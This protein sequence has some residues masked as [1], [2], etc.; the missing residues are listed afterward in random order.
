MQ[1]R[2]TAAT[3]TLDP[4]DYAHPPDIPA[5]RRAE[6]AD[7]RLMLPAIAPSTAWPAAALARRYVAPDYP[8]RRRLGR[9][10]R[11]SS[12]RGSFLPYEESRAAEPPLLSQPR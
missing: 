7:T 2:R 9:A 6:D 11:S 4:M 1:Y 10:R 12:S 3:R 8:R 5:Q